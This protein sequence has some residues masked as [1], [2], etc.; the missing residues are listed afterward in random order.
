MRNGFF[1]NIL[2]L[3]FLFGLFACGGGGQSSMS[4]GSISSGSN[5]SGESIV[6]GSESPNFST[7]EPI[8][9]PVP[10]AKGV[11][12]VDATQFSFEI[13]GGN[14][15]INQALRQ[16]VL[17]S[18]GGTHTI[19]SGKTQVANVTV[20][21]YVNGNIVCTDTSASDRSFTCDIEGNACGSAVLFIVRGAN[22]TGSY[23][24]TFI[25]DAADDVIDTA[26]SN[27]FITNIT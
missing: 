16:D 15:N 20:D 2:F 4:C 6:P 11:D 26:H 18:H 23:P 13:S 25:C 5:A 24:V 19:V 1:K 12:P 9:I 7:S 27:Q 10:I 14:G 21:G 8:D 17:A 22:G 3:L